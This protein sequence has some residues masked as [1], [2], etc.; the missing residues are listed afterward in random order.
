MKFGSILILLAISVLVDAATYY[1]INNGTSQQVDEFSICQEVANNSGLDIHVPTKT[2]AEWA[3]FRSFPP[4]GV[5]LTSCAAV[6]PDAIIDLNYAGL[7]NSAVS[8]AWTEPNDNGT[9]IT[10]YLVEYKETASGTW[11]VFADGTSTATT[12]TV[13]GLLPS[14]SYDF[15]VAALNGA[16][17]AYSNI[18]TQTT[19]PN[20]PFFDPAVFT[21]LNCGGATSTAVVALDDNTNIDLNGSPLAGSPINA[22]QVIV[23][24]SVLGDTLTA[25]KPIFAAGRLATSNSNANEGNIAWNTPSWA[26]KDFIIVGSRNPEHVVTV[27]AFENTNITITQGATVHFNNDPV[28]AGN[29]RTYRLPNNAGYKITS[30]A[31]ITAYQYSEDATNAMVVDNMPI[32]PPSTDIIGV[33]SQT[34]Q[35]TTIAASTAF[36]WYESD[37]TTNGATLTEGVFASYG[38]NGNN[39]A[40]PSARAIAN[41]GIIGRSNADADGNDSEPFVPK[42][43]MKRRFAVN[44]LSEWV[45]FASIYPAV[46]RVFPP[47]GA[48]TT[49]TLTR[50]G[51]GAN[52]PYFGRLTAVARGTIFES[53]VVFQAWYES[54]EAGEASS[55]QEDETI[56][57]GDYGAFLPVNHKL[58]LWLDASD[59]QTMF[60][61]DDCTGIVAAN[62]QNVGCWRDKSPQGNHAIQDG[63]NKPTFAES[64]AAFGDQR[65]VDF[66][67]GTNYLKFNSSIVTGTAYTIFAVVHRDTTASSN[68]F[69]GTQTAAAN[70]GL[71]LGFSTD[72]QVRLGQFSNDLNATVTGQADNSVGIFWGRLNTTSGKKV[73]FNNVSATD[74]TTT[75]LSSPGQGVIGRGYDTNGFDGQIAEL[76]IYDRALSDAEVDLIEAYL[77]EKWLAP[78][79][80][81]NIRLWLDA[82][83]SSRVFSDAGCTTNV[84]NGGNVLC[85]QDRSGRNYLAKSSSGTPIWQADGARNIITFTNDSL[86]IDG[87]TTGAP[88]TSGNTVS[89]LDV[90]AV[91]KSASSVETGY[92][93][94]HPAGNDLSAH[95]PW[96]G[97]VEFSHDTG[98]N[99]TISAAWG[100]NTTNYFMW[101]F[102]S[103]NPGAY[104]GIYRDMTLVTSDATASTLTIGTENF[105]IGAQ[106]GSSNFQN[107]NLGALLM[108]DKRLTADQRHMVRAY[109]RNRWGL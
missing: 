99:G 70:Q 33:P 80:I 24:A 105:Y 40:A 11:L 106:N 67:G 89:E 6:P 62:G 39:Y 47:A 68:Y 46:I 102:V 9:A 38:G 15:R 43:F 59:A 45:A 101:N 78:N 91:M 75:T 19:A 77:I 76:I 57:V 83:E 65:G 2:A 12:A 73:Y 109:L 32:I 14:T 60:Q 69:I 53:D 8:L 84:T 93:F 71:H 92:L 49:F 50:T 82:S 51:S 52:T 22:G 66:N 21:A 23:F 10:D 26:A 37:N 63:G 58:K 100:A 64:V 4:T 5:T 81:D 18:V 31:L 42:S 72:T 28:A 86:Q 35:Y 34:G 29:F 94:H 97:N 103:D 107:M 20:D 98:A 36:N 104:Q 95:V 55:A 61:N 44:Q 13:T 54:D 56:L 17:G 108:F 79:L 85:W 30:T 74:A 88:F 25:D 41:D 96:S 90:F 48:P 3:A 1:R 16:Q 7:S 27:Y 87:S